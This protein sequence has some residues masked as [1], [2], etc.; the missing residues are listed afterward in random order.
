[1]GER[2]S[3]RKDIAPSGMRM[4]YTA[5][6]ATEPVTPARATAKVSVRGPTLATI[7]RTTALMSPECS[8]TAT[9]SITVMMS[10]SGGNDV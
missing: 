5:S 9:P 8:A 1:M 10:P 6:D 2:P 3:A 7:A 4:T